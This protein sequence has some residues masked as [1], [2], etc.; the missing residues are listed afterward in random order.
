MLGLR[1]SCLAVTAE[2]DRDSRS[3]HTQRASDGVAKKKS[4]RA[5]RSDEAKRITRM[6]DSR[7]KKI[8]RAQLSVRELEETRARERNNKRRER[9]GRPQSHVLL[10]RQKDRQRKKDQREK[11]KSLKLGEKRDNLTTEEVEAK[12]RRDPSQTQPQVMTGDDVLKHANAPFALL[13]PETLH[14]SES[15][16]PHV[17]RDHASQRQGTCS[18]SSF[19]I[20]T[21]PGPSYYIDA[22]NANEV[23]ENALFLAEV[24]APVFQDGRIQRARNTTNGGPSMQDAVANISVEGEVPSV[25]GH[26]GSFEDACG[27]LHSHLGAV[28][29]P[30]ANLLDF[31]FSGGDELLL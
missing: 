2:V 26:V 21:T 18:E 25:Y 15:S 24:L 6:K 30:G 31:L 11:L 3:L 23:P 22:N 13:E 7:A 1:E 29:S 5:N 20:P 4:F 16:C 19:S 12:A 17:S 28:S 27:E 10:A 8:R 14:R 9:A